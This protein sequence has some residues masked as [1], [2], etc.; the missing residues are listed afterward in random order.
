MKNYLRLS[1]ITYISLLTISLFCLSITIIVEADGDTIK[2]LPVQNSLI[3][4]KLIH[5]TGKAAP[6]NSEIE[7]DQIVK[8]TYNKDSIYIV[9]VKTNIGDKRGCYI[10][11]FDE[12]LNV[13]QKI[14]ISDI[15]EAESCEIIK[16]IF[17][18]NMIQNQSSGVGVL[19]GKRLGSDHYWF[20]GS[21]LTLNQTGTL[22]E[23]KKLS[24]RLNDI[25]NVF[26][27]KKKLGCR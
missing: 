16:V 12:K 27:A 3:S 6:K 18:C 5:Q 8:I 9:P 17:S 4:K 15:E 19:Y 13:S 10:Y 22:S 11:K 14:K 24:E 21:Y 20:E 7:E 26:K 2:A 1:D 25:D 23:D